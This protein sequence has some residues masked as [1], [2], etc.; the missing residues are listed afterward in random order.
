MDNTRDKKKRVLTLSQEKYVEK[1]L[2]PFGMSLGKG[3]DNYSGFTAQVG[4]LN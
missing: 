4:E 3:N 1:V 2:S